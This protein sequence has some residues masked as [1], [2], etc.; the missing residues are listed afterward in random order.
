L[1]CGKKHHSLLHEESNEVT[2]NFMPDP[3]KHV[4]ISTATVPVLDHDGR[5]VWSRALLDNGSECRVLTEV[6][7]TRIKGIGNH[8]TCTSTHLDRLNPGGENGFACIQICAERT[9]EVIDVDDAMLLPT[10]TGFLPSKSIDTT[11][12]TELD[13]LRLAD[14]NWHT[15]GKVDL[16]LGQMYS[17]ILCSQET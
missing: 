11:E 15:S 14:P 12:L 16:L 13:D 17:S 6:G 7:F 8:V 9:G 1:V 4:V 10:I 2:V 5:V 3:S